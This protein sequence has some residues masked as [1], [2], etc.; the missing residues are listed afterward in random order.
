MSFIIDQ[1][2]SFNTNAELKKYKKDE[3]IQSEGNYSQCFYYLVKGELSV[4]HFTEEGKE[5]LQHKVFNQSFFGE[6]AVLLGRPFPGNVVVTSEC[7][8]VYKINKDNF[9]NYLKQIGRAHV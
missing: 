9:L 4:F 2:F 3:L 6:P 8:E 1:E 7:A 5:F